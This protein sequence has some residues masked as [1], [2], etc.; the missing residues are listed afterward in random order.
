[1]G[2]EGGGVR[3]RKSTRKFPPCDALGDAEMREMSKRDLPLLKKMLEVTQRCERER[4]LIDNQE[5][6]ESR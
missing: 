1:M 3:R 6:T 2:L 5:V 4:S